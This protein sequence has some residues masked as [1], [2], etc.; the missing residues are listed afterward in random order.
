MDIPKRVPIGTKLNRG[1][2][3]GSI[4]GP[5]FFLLYNNDSP[6]IINNISKLILYA[7]DTSIIFS[8]SNSTDYVTFIVTFDKMNLRFTINSLSFNL[9]KCNY[10]HFTTK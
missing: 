9:F 7:D 4:F 10:V 8:N 1:V 5:L 3:Q 6:Y 2:T